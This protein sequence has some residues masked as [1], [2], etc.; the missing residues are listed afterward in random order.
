MVVSRR[1]K[2]LVQ[3]GPNISTTQQRVGLTMKQSLFQLE[4]HGHHH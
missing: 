4:K 1:G 2:I 3:Q